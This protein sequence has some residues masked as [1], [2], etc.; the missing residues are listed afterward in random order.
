[1]NRR[2]TLV[3]SAF[4][5]LVSAFLTPP[6]GAQGARVYRIGVVEQGGPY[7]EAIEGLREGLRE[8]GLEEGKHYALKVTDA[9]GVIKVVEA[10]ARQLEAD[11]VD[12]IFAVSSSTALAVKKA[13]SRVPIVFYAGTDPVES[14]LV[15][16]FRKPGGRLTGVFG[17]QSDVTPKRLE[18][19]KAIMPKL[20]R[21]LTPYNPDNSIA[22]RALASA[23][24]AA[25]QLK[26]QLVERRVATP[27][28]LRAAVRAIKP[29]EVEALFYVPD[30]MVTSQV[31]M[32]I[33]TAR[34]KRFATMFTDTSTVGRGAL[35]SYGI[36]FRAVGKL[37]A[38]HVQGVLKG[39]P[40]G[41]I[42]VEQMDRLHFAINLKTAK[43]IGLTVPHPV[44]MRADEVVQ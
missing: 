31:D 23:H 13:T 43:E 9:K 1:M 12:L 29:G 37:A 28:E 11:K 24:D 14:G 33:E 10:A 32:I 41:D 3:L 4:A 42:P 25:Q 2:R 22:V 30:A 20:A 26:V 38:K 39:T 5:L 27:D 21:V 7:S 15:A 35:A 17:R 6:A 36:S 40:P 8:G 16:S 18:L 44:L 19:L 34:E